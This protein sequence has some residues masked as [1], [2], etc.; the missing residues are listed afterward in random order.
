MPTYRVKTGG[1]EYEVSVTDSGRGASVTVEGKTFDVEAV[2]APPPPRSPD[3][4]AQS[5]TPAQPAPPPASLKPA[6][7]GSG[8]IVAPI[9]GVITTVEVSRGDKV[10]V[11]Q[12]VVKLEA[13]K[14]ENA[15]N[16]TIDG[17]VQEVCV[18]EG[19][20]VSDGQTLVII[21]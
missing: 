19:D 9:P 8:T 6:A 13:M 10:T 15:I 21:A 4:S 14:M 11:G 18:S 1:R 12:T 7:V 16:S 17:E 3:G 20:Q 2:A 5:S